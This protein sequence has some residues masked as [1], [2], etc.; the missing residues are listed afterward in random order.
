M[1][2]PAGTSRVASTV[3]T[4]ALDPV[5]ATPCSIFVNLHF[6]RGRKFVKELAVVRDF[7]GFICLDVVKRIRQRHF[8]VPVV[9]AIRFA[10]SRDV[11]QLV[12]GLIVGQS[13]NQA[14]CEFFA[15]FQNALK[16]N[17]L[18]DRSVVK[19]HAHWAAA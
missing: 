3:A 11:S 15:I 9:M 8:S 19:K 5:R 6:M 12:Y 18:R 1:L 16:G 7:G 10:V 2:G 4:P 14:R 13:A 17:G